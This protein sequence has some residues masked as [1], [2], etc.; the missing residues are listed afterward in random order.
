MWAGCSVGI[1]V[2]RPA[3]L[4]SN[5]SCGVHAPSA[6]VWKKG[7]EPKSSLKS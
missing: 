2:C 5:V 1:R 6:P 7:L 3:E 4:K